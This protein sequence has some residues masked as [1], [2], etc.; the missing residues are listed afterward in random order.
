MRF[1]VTSLVALL[2]FS[3]FS[4][5]AVAGSI[6]EAVPINRSRIRVPVA[7][8]NTLSPAIAAAVRMQGGQRKSMQLLA[9]APSNVPAFVLPAQIQNPFAQWRMG[10]VRFLILKQRNFITFLNLE[11]GEQEWAGV[12]VS[13]D[14]GRTWNKFFTVINPLADDG[15]GGLEEN[16]VNVEHLFVRGGVLYLD[17]TDGRGAGSGEGKL[18][19]L[20]SRDGGL[21]WQ[22]VACLYFMPEDYYPAGYE[23]YEN[24]GYADRSLATPFNLRDAVE[25]A[26]P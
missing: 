15:L 8:G 1:I 5:T 23:A 18:T 11:Y 21:T 12:L 6:D 25:C 13:T 19:R 16:P 24:S 9:E 2:T 10:A 7:S 17:L 26:Y 14:G 3:S 22:R 20:R 4:I